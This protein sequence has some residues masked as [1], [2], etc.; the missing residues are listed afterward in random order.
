M[1]PF[2]YLRCDSVAEAC[3][4]LDAEGGAARILAGGTDLLPELRRSEV[5]PGTIVDIGGISSLRGIPLR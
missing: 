2:E 5:S 1:R 4:V 3:R